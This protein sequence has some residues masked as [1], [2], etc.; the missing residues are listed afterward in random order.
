MLRCVNSVVVV[1]YT[2]AYSLFSL[3]FIFFVRL[4]VVYDVVGLR[5]LL[6]AFCLCT[7]LLVN[8]V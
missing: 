4:L 1:Y 3:M 6:I 8:G 5:C 2:F 7:W